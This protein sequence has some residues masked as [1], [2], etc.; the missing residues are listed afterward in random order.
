MRRLANPFVA[1][2]VG[3]MMCLGGALLFFTAPRASANDSPESLLAQ[4]RTAAATHDFSGVVHVRWL[5]PRGVQTSNVPVSSDQGRVQVGLGSQM[6]VGEGL[7]RWAGPEGAATL[8]HDAGPSQLPDPSA[9]WELSTVSGPRIVNRPTTVVVARDHD[10]HTR[11]RLYLDQATG[12]LLRREILDSRGRDVHDVKFVALSPV[13]PKVAGQP[14]PPTP[15]TQR[16]RTDDHLSKVPSGYAAPS[17]AG[18]GFRL[19]GR[20]RQSEGVVQLLYSDGLFNVS[21]F[22][23]HGDLDWD[24]LPPGGTDQTVAGQHTRSYET[25][26]GT[27]L[28]WNRDGNVYTTI[29]DAPSDMVRQMVST[30]TGVSGS[31][32]DAIHDA[33][34]FV[35]GPFS[36]G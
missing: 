11:A 20:Y 16:Q 4:S 33:I 27:V 2:G 5:T 23:Q 18:A 1:L 9:K 6:V 24:A 8:W 30:F 34:H 25:A 12:L 13:A 28:F 19:V 29:S 17:S 3:V 15:N 22:E 32:S 26:A 35:L 7:D 36:W 14:A 21:V 10:G 31:G